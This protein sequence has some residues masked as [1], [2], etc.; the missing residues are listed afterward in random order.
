MLGTLPSGGRVA[1]RLGARDQPAG[2]S[3]S[4][5]IASTARGCPSSFPMLLVGDGR[6]SL[7][8]VDL[9]RDGA[10]EHLPG[11]VPRDVSRARAARDA[12][13]DLRDSLLHPEP[14]RTRPAV[15]SAA[16]VLSDRSSGRRM[17]ADGLR[18]ALLCVAGFVGDRDPLLRDRRVEVASPISSG[19]A[20]FSRAEAEATSSDR[21]ASH[22]SGSEAL[23][24]RRRSLRPLRAGRSLRRRGR[25]SPRIS[26]VV[27]A[28]GRRRRPVPAI[29]RREA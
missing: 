14:D 12:G 2:T 22:P 9:R 6:T 1:D 8:A 3:G 5:P 23:R 11:A 13:A 25:A 7:I 17:G 15:R 29:D 19:A 21:R 20:S 26:C 4:R 24:L 27:L 16:G 10:D 18:Y 28:H